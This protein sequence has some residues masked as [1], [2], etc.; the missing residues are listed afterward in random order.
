MIKLTSKIYIHI[1][2]VVMLAVCAMSRHTEVFLFSYTVMTLHE[3]AH[4]TAAVFIGL[5]TDKIVFYP[6]GVNL[7]LKNKFVHNLSDEIILYLSGPL[8][9]CLLA[10]PALILYRIYKLPYL[11]VF[12]VGNIMFFISNMLPVYPLDGGVLLKKITAHFWGQRASTV[13][14]TVISCIF[15]TALLA[16]SVY[17]IYMT[18]FNFSVIL[19][20]AFLICSLFT[21]NEKY[22]VDFVRELMFYKNKK[23]NKIKNIIADEA[24]D[25]KQIAKKFRDGSYALVFV[26]NDRGEIT[27]IMSEREIMDKITGGTD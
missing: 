17:M 9:N 1:L 10:L 8:M 16:L 18:E 25:C 14:M 6:Y 13:I 19:L 15:I 21:Q 11:Q 7:K 4:F 23:K 24:D 22:D 2:T 3:L 20:T 27:K 12:Y 26:E 5:K